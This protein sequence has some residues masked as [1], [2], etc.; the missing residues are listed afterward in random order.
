MSLPST[1]EEPPL[2]VLISYAYLR[3]IADDRVRKILTDPRVAYLI[4][5]GAFS[6]LNSGDDPI[7][8]ERY[9]SFLERWNDHIWGAIQLDVLGDPDAS[10]RNLHQMIDAG[11]DPIPVH[12]WGDRQERMDELFEL[13]PVVALGGL[14]RP[15]RGWAPKSYVKQKMEWSRGRPVHWLGYTDKQMVA[16]FRPYS[17]DCSNVTYAE[18]MGEVHIYNGGGT[19]DKVISPRKRRD[20][21]KGPG[22]APLTA[23]RQRLI[24]RLG[25]TEEDWYDERKWRRTKSQTGLEEDDHVASAVTWNSHV[26][27]CLDLQD[28]LGVRYFLAV[29]TDDWEMIDRQLTIEGYDDE[30]DL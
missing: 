23:E 29:G 9:I 13:S 30:R 3:D 17:F 1:D 5:S 8:I 22:P 18:R 24:E 20:R 2:Y 6:D 19:M 25:Y 4:D 26:R 10:E 15:G 21:G 11:C 7:E 27:Y 14:R 12:V 16:S 28:V